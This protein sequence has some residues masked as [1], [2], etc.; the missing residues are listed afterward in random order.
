MSVRALLAAII[1]ITLVGPA[2]AAKPTSPATPVISG[3]PEDPTT[4]TSATFVFSSS[5]DGSS[6]LCSLDSASFW[7]ARAPR[8]TA[9]WPLAITYSE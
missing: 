8:A 9:G 6:Y 2:Q 4:A 3:G 1:L 5:T 7:P